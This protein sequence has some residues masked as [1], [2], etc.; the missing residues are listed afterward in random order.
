MNDLPPELF[1]HWL[2]SQEEDTPDIFVYR[3]RGYPFPRVRGREGIIISPGGEFQSIEI[4]PT[5]GYISKKG[6][7][8]KQG[9]NVILVHFE[10]P[11]HPSL[12]L[13]ILFVNEKILKIAHGMCL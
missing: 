3:P 10:D 9:S 2:H 8:K 12:I 4:A 5:D 11:L 6:V 7:W 1:K 13:H